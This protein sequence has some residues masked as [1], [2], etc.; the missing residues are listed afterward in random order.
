MESVHAGP[1]RA[2]VLAQSK[3]VAGTGQRIHPRRF[4]EGV[5]DARELGHIRVG[6]AMER[7]DLLQL[8]VILDLGALQ[9]DVTGQ[10]RGDRDDAHD[11]Q[12]A[13]VHDAEDRAR[14]EHEIA[15]GDHGVPRQPPHMCAR[16][17]GD[18]QRDEARDE[19]QV[20]DGLDRELRHEE[21]SHRRREHDGQR[22]ERGDRFGSSAKPV[23]EGVDAEECEGGDR[24]VQREKDGPHARL[25]VVQRDRVE[26]DGGRD[27]DE[28]DA[29]GC[30]GPTSL[31]GTELR[32]RSDGRV[33][34]LADPGQEPAG[35]DGEPRSR[36]IG[37]PHADAGREWSRRS[38]RS[39]LRPDAAT[40]PDLIVTAPHMADGASEVRL[41]CASARGRRG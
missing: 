20:A 25:D 39:I 41:R 32:A 31:D 29:T 30:Y 3:A 13:A 22:D 24:A 12:V 35:L 23:A 7:L 34:A 9:Q 19:Q 40:V 1:G 33:L 4:L 6:S 28:P 21:G 15:I 17:P 27:D 5:V 37:P 10:A 26:E 38:H 11:D 18:D 36:R 16:A 14:P 2:E 8:G